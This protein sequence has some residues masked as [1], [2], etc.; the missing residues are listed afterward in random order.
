MSREVP[1]AVYIPLAEL[2]K[3][4]LE[5]PPPHKLVRVVHDSV[6]A[7][8]ALGW[9]HAR[10]W[11]AVLSEPPAE[12][13]PNTRY[14]LWEPNE[15]LQAVVPHLAVGR[16]LDLGCGT[17][18]DAVFLADLG[19][20]VVAVDRLPEALERGRTLQRRYAPESPPV[21]W[22]CA[23]LEGSNWS[24]TGA[25]DLI[26]LFFFFS[27]VVVERAL[28]WLAPSGSLLIEAFTAEHR[29]HYGKPASEARI[30]SADALRQRVGNVLN[31][32]HC[33]E[34]WRASGRHTVRLWARR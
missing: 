32:L 11:R 6:A 31:I 9:L 34:G 28:Q 29:A 2:P 8:Y 15:W 12:A 7:Y 19:W 30:T 10:G 14:R 27:W 16:A 20:Q 1:G 18:R 23:D 22:V 4:T 25:F 26:T 5:L 24:P 3:R 21:E 13:Q 33:S 17:G